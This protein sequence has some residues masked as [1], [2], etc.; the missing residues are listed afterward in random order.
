VPPTRADGDNQFYMHWGWTTPAQRF[1]MSA[2]RYLRDTGTTTKAFAEV[3]MA[4]RY[5]ASLNPKAIMRAPITI[6]DHQRSRWVVKPFR[7]LD[8]CLETDVSAALIVTSRERAYD[9][10]QPPVFIL[11]GTARTMAPSPAW[12]YSRPEIHYVAGNYGRKRL[13]GMAGI[14]Q[15]DVDFISCYDAFTFTTLIQL[16]AYGFCGKGE[17]GEFVKGGRLQLDHELPSNLSGGHLSEGYTHGI[18]MVIEN[19]R[20]LR[21]RA[22]DA[23]PGWAEGKHTYDR[24]AGCRQVRNGRIAACLGWGTEATSSSVILR[25]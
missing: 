7:L 13:F 22:D 23:C 12:N 3:A 11:G 9:L 17:A 6:A 20:Q 24:Q 19:V 16:E 18:S 25:S 10:R 5:H 21:H 15:K 1:G 14:N 2:M 4:H 8:C